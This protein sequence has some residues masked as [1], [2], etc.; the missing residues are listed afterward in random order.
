MQRSFTSINYPDASQTVAFGINNSGSIVGYYRDAIGHTHGFLYEGGT[1]SSIDFPGASETYAVGINNS[2][3]LVGWYALTIHGPGRGF[4]YSG[5]S[6]I[7]LDAPGASQTIAN[8]IND[9]GNIAGYYYDATGPHG[10]LTSPWTISII[11]SAGDVGLDSSIAIDSNN[12]V[13]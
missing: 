2:G 13:I 7:T 4:L 3:D 6:F 10:F 8:G 5:G 11:D 12:K 9:S 1:F